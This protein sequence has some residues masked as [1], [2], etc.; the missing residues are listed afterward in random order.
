LHGNDFVA[1]L[2]KM[3]ELQQFKQM[4]VYIEACY[5]AALF[6]NSLPSNIR[7]FNIIF[8]YFKMLGILAVTAAN[9]QENSWSKY[10]GETEHDLQ[11][12]GDEM[13]FFCLV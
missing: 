7:M 10:C 12:L 1:A 11:C 13:F 9:R 3:Y 6:E 4:I 5:S 2:K 8:I